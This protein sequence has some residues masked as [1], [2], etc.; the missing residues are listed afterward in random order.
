MAYYT[1]TDSGLRYAGIGHSTWNADVNN[2]N[3]TRL[4]NTLLKFSALLDI[5]TSGLTDGDIMV[6]NSSTQNWERKP[7]PPG[8][9][10][11]TTTTT[12]TSTTTTTT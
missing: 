7:L 10:P 2:Y 4:N 8:Y 3:W 6:Y 5:D 1:L 9:S 11:V 12:T